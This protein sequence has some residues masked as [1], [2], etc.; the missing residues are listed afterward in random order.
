MVEYIFWRIGEVDNGIK[1]WSKDSG[2]DGEVQ[3]E[4]MVK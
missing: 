3:M 4:L 1:W 2:V